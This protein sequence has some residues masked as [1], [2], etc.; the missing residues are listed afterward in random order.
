MS[1]ETRLREGSTVKYCD[2]GNRAREMGQFVLSK[3]TLRKWRERGAATNRMYNIQG[4]VI[5][6]WIWIPIE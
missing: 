6:T 4:V 3:F 2:S 1:S 5:R